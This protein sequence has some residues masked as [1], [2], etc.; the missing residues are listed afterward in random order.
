MRASLL[1]VTLL[2]AGALLAAAGTL[3][4]HARSRRRYV[5]RRISPDQL[6]RWPERGSLVPGALAPR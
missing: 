4:L 6:A 2:V 3:R 5:R 1:L